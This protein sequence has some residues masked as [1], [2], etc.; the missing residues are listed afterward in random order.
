MSSVHMGMKYPGDKLTTP[1]KGRR[2]VLLLSGGIDSTVVLEML[3]RND[4]QVH[5]LS[6]DYGQR[7]S[8]ELEAASRVA[9]FYGIDW[10]R[11][12]VD[13]SGLLLS[14]LTGS[15]APTTKTLEEVRAQG[16]S[17]YFVLGRNMIFLSFALGLAQSLG[18]GFIFVGATLEDN[19]EFPDC[20]PKFFE[21]FGKVASLATEKKIEVRAP[22]IQMRKQDV[23]T[24]GHELKAPLE[25]TISCYHATDVIHCGRCPACLIRREAF[26]NAGIEDPTRYRS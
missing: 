6:V 16:R 9:G 22:L 7:H 21:S 23:V 24:V 13:A 3:R 4:W 25:L 19:A 14:P 11:V 2:C 12:N 18:I 10:R 17:G 20:R 15:Q 1:I 8:F 5:A 26:E